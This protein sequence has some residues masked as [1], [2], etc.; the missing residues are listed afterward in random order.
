VTATSKHELQIE[1]ENF[2][3]AFEGGR[4][5]VSWKWNDACRKT[6]LKNEIDQYSIINVAWEEEVEI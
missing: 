6:T 2:T 1:D 4:W 3:A 5:V